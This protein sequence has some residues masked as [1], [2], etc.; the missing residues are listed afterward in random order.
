M[1]QEFALFCHSVIWQIISVPF[2]NYV[3]LIALQSDNT[4]LKFAKVG[5]HV[6]SFP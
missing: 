3:N 6:V 5:G 1:T 4:G 2:K